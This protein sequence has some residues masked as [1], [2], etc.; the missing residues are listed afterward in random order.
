[1]SDINSYIH[2]LKSLAKDEASYEEIK[3]IISK[4]RREDLVSFVRNILGK[5]NMFFFELQNME[6]AGDRPIIYSPNVVDIIGYTHEELES[7]PKLFTSLINE[8]DLIKVKKVTAEIKNAV[9]PKNYELT[10]RIKS[11]NGKTVWLK[12]NVHVQF[13]GNVQK[14]IFAVYTN[15]T[16]FIEREEALINLKETY[17][18]KNSAKD[19]FI[20]IVSHDLRAPFTSLLGFSEILLKEEDIS[21]DEA[22][23]YLEYIYNAAKTE[24]QLINDL[25]D[26]SRLQTGKINLNIRRVRLSDVINNA[27]S[28]LTGSA[29]RKN[30]TVKIDV[31]EDIFVLADDRLLG[32]AVKNLL[33]NALK[34]TPADKSIYITAGKFNEGVV[35]V[36][37]RDEGVGIPEKHQDKLFKIDEKFT[38]DGTEGEKG[39]GL[40][41]TLVKEI[42]DKHRGNIWFYSKENEGTEFH[43]TLPEAHTKVFVV[44]DD[45]VSRK[46]IVQILK[47]NLNNCEIIEASNGYEALSKIDSQTPS[48]IITDHEM[49]LMN[50]V[51]LAEAVKKKFATVKLPII[52]VSG[53]LNDELKKKYKEL[54]IEHI[55]EKPVLPE[56]FGSIIKT[57]LE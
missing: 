21:S 38:L 32:Q 7:D 46:L 26:W 22:R 43:F 2:Q 35:E 20:S 55:I 11:A 29:I 45:M 16:D 19:K 27:A 13:E 18:E 9:E 50:G 31:S 36:V 25:L 15:I 3:G 41:L 51:Q 28:V 53:V 4:I 17:R 24:L 1:M 30:V 44:E 48:L 34:F 47:D 33:S 8:D 57:L 52:I 56:N 10:F 37:I 5:S 40:G 6:N 23:E 42:I 49:P 14:N 54:G 39:S 12:K